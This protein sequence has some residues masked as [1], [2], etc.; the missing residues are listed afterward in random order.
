MRA[1]EHPETLYQAFLDQTVSAGVPGITAAV[2]ASNGVV[3]TAASGIANLATGERMRPDM[4]LGI[5]SITKTFVAVVILQLIDEKRLH[6]DHTAKD[7][8]G[9]VVDGLPNAD[10]ATVAQLLNHTSGIPSWEDDPTWIRHGR[11]NLLDA[12][13]I[14]G[15]LDTLGYI[16]GKKRL[17]AAGKKYSYSNTNYTLL[18]MI[19]E[20]VTGMEAVTVIH[21]RVLEPL[22]LQDVFVEGFESVPQNRLPRR[23]HWATQ[24]F[25]RAA[26]VNAAFTEVRAELIDASPSNLSTEWMAGGMLATARDLALYGLALRDGR[27]L[28]TESM[29][30]MTDWALVGPDTQVGHGLF[31]ISYPGGFAIV[32]HNG[33][34]LGFTA[35]LYWIEG[36]DAV[37]SMMCNVGAMH[38]GT[39]PIAINSVE[40]QKQFIDT[41]LRSK[42][43][44]SVEN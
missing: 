9:V 29:E 25:R 42:R 5:G 32:R 18:G 12:G 26:G 13:R 44:G 37:V 40:K 34:V 17:A 19:V 16:K 35:T 2:A 1:S 28:K 8:L 20:K 36:V 33:D 7:I 23:Y 39:V 43:R 4:L 30:F 6:P 14:W 31:R 22:G 11:G 15:K 24:D 10:T 38:A 27:L 21:E 3:W 41:V